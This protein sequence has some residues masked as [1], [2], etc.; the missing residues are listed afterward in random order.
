MKHVIHLAIAAIFSLVATTSGAS[1]FLR[2]GVAGTANAWTVKFACTLDAGIPRAATDIKLCPTSS[3]CKV[4]TNVTSLSALAIGKFTN[5]KATYAIRLSNCVGT[6]A[7]G[8]AAGCLVESIRWVVGYSRAHRHVYLLFLYWGDTCIWY[9]TNEGQPGQ[10]KYGPAAHQVA[11]QELFASWR[12]DPSVDLRPYLV[13]G[14]NTVWMRTV[15]SG[16]GEGWIE[17]LARQACPSTCTDS[18][19]TEA[20]DEHG[21]PSATN[22]D[23]DIPCDVL[24]DC[25]PENPC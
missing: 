15:V 13:N 22:H 3:D 6:D 10:V 25:G 23:Q 5:F 12:I 4:A 18:W 11:G 21:R 8:N 2:C 14:T 9:C 16:R 20:T 7:N 1:E 24:E 19:D 17:I